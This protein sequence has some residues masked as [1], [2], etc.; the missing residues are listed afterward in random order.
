MKKSILI[1]SML[2][3]TGLIFKSNAFGGCESSLPN[4]LQACF[5]SSHLT[6]DVD[7]SVHGIITVTGNLT[8]EEQAVICE[9]CI[10]DYNTG[11][12]SCPAAPTLVIGMITFN[13]SATSQTS[14]K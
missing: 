8:S 3:L 10:E 6:M 1:L 13:T 14:H 11:A 5:N 12:A 9:A 7:Q 2:M 4:Q